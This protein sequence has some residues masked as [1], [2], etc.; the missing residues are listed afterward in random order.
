MNNN[1]KRMLVVFSVLGFGFAGMFLT[2][3]DD[4]LG[5]DNQSRH[6]I[7]VLFLII[8]SL[9]AGMGIGLLAV[10]PKKPKKQEQTI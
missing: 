3:G 2:A 4:W 5:F 1:Q 9:V 6:Y 7:P 8:F 10:L